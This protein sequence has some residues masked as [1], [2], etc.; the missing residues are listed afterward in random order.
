MNLEALLRSRIPVT[1]APRGLSMYPFIRPSDRVTIIPGNG[2]ISVGEVV[3]LRNERGR[4]MI[5][6]V[7]GRRRDSGRWITRGDSLLCPDQPVAPDRVWGRIIGVE[8][9]GRRKTYRLSSPFRRYLGRLIAASSRLESRLVCCRAARR[10]ASA[11]FFPK[12]A[13]KL[14]RWILTRIFFR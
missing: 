2:D 10:L 14:P 4:W 6:R 3:L 5:H 12:K 13:V 1:I 11:G 7:I 8:R 9:R